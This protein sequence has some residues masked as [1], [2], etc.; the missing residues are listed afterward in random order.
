MARGNGFAELA[1][2]GAVVLGALF[3]VAALSPKQTQGPCSL[4]APPALIADAPEAS[5]LAISRRH[6]GFFWTHNDSGN[7]PD[8]FAF[9]AHGSVQGQVR[10]SVSNSDWDDISVGACAAG[11]CL[12]VGDIGD[13]DLA[14]KS[15]QVYRL[16][17]PD[18][19]RSQTARPD[20]FTFIYPDGP[21]NA[22]AAFLADGH[23]FIVTKDLTGTVYR[24]TTRV[25]DK[26]EGGEIKLERVG[27]LGLGAVSDAEASAD[28]ASVAVRTAEEVVLYRTS[29]VRRGGDIAPSMRISVTGLREP[30]GEGVALGEDGMVYMTSEGRPW[31]PAGRLVSLR[32]ST[33]LL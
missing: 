31:K 26:T 23:L 4:S 22:E 6:N 13:N 7:A 14:R 18:L 2:A 8:L 9:N 3:A 25:D 19:Q 5:G 24:S 10:L 33:R 27:D 15:V 32:C 28:G 1:A 30:D 20:V 11:D 12:Y 21:H 17:E 29:D 16:P